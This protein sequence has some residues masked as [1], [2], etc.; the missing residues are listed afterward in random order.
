MLWHHLDGLNIATTLWIYSDTILSFFFVAKEKSSQVE[1]TEAAHDA[2][3]STQAAACAP[4]AHQEAGG[5]SASQSAIDAQKAASAASQ[6]NRS[7]SSRAMENAP[8]SMERK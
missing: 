5:A 7:G 1:F 4:P 3:P 6:L 8:D 2:N